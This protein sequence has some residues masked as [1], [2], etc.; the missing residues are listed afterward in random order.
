MNVSVANVTLT[1]CTDPCW[2]F[3]ADES[4]FTT[5]KTG[6]KKSQVQTKAVPIL[7]FH[8]RY[9]ADISASA[10]TDINPIAAGYR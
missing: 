6:K 7:Y 9:S 1:A 4:I 3:L 5:S 8:F 2:A 10:N